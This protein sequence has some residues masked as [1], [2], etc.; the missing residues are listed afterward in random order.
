MRRT[1][2]ILVEYP[3]RPE[4]STSI[5]VGPIPTVSSYRGKWFKDPR[6]CERPNHIPHPSP[7]NGNYHEWVETYRVQLEQLTRILVTTVDE[8]VPRHGIKWGAD[9]RITSNFAKVLYHCSSKYISPHIESP[10][11]GVATDY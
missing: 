3:T 2:P 10:S 8:E 9:P 1:R 11:K 4:N 6:R 7:K 5:P